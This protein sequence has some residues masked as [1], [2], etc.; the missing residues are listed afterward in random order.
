MILRI[1]NPIQLANRAFIVSPG[2]KA[3]LAI[4]SALRLVWVYHDR[5]HPPKISVNNTPT[6]QT[7]IKVIENERTLKCLRI[8]PIN[9]G[10]NAHAITYPP[11]G[12]KRTV[13]PF[14]CP[15][16]TGIPQKPMIKNNQ[17]LKVPFLVPKI[18]AANMIPKF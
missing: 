17:T 11:D 2:I 14:A 12:E 1:R 4:K 18:I 7:V 8:K 16:K 6:N 5:K 3:K 10:V 13:K 15:G 9:S